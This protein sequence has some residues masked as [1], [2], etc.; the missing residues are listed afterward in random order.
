VSRFAAGTHSTLPR[1]ERGLTI[2]RRVLALLLAV[3]IAAAALTAACS[4]S[5]DELEELR[6]LPEAEL[7][8]AGS[9]VLATSGRDG[10]RTIEGPQPAKYIV[11]LGSD[12]RVEEIDAFYAQAL[13]ERGWTELVASVFAAR[14]STETD[15]DAW[16]KDGIIFRLSFR[17]LTGLQAP[18]ADLLERYETIYEIRL[19]PEDY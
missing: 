16:R 12:A 18:A 8:Y 4:S 9:E 5:Q 19:F 1:Q 2:R 11:Q 7:F 10:R 6:G 15:T 3:A 17:R 14:G 13:P